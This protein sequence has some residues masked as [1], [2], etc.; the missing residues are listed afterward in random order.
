[1]AISEQQLETWSNTGADTGS[2]RAYDRVKNIID[3]SNFT[4]KSEVDI[5]LQ[6]SYANTTHIRA[7]SDVDVVIQLT[8]VFS[9]DISKLS[10]QEKQEYSKLSN[11]TYS[12]DHLRQELLNIFTN[13]LGSNNVESRN[14]CIRLNLGDGHLSVDLTPCTSYRIYHSYPTQHVEGISIKKL[15]GNIIHNFPKRHI[16]H[17]TRKHKNTNEYYKKVVRILKNMRNKL[18]EEGKIAKGIA[19]SYFVECLA[20]NTPNNSFGS[21]LYNSV[22]NSLKWF[23]ENHNNFGHLKCQNEVTN[24]FGSEGTQWN[25]PHCQ[26]FTSA[27]ITLWNGS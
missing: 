5:Y 12:H 13:V 3:N 17:G 8:S 22:L 15:D 7:D 26:A 4:K 27:I 19:P 24:L 20:Y 14:K 16:D 21:S 2:K 11:A 1:M 25:V 6:G 23:S 10:E 9:S 18:T